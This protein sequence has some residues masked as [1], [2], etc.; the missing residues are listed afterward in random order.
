L[1]DEMEKAGL[2]DTTGTTAQPRAVFYG[3]LWLIPINRSQLPYESM[4][5]NTNLFKYKGPSLFSSGD[6]TVIWQDVKFFHPVMLLS[7]PKDYS[8]FRSSTECLAAVSMPDNDDTVGITDNKLGLSPSHVFQKHCLTV[9]N[10][11]FAQ[12]SAGNGNDTLLSFPVSPSAILTDSPASLLQQC[13]A[14]IQYL[15]QRE[16]SM[17]YFGQALLDTD[18]LVWNEGNRTSTHSC[19]AFNAALQCN[20]MRQLHCHSDQDRVV[21]PFLFYEMGLRSEYKSRRR[22]IDSYFQRR[23]HHRFFLW[24]EQEGGGGNDSD[25]HRKEGVEQKDAVKIVRGLCHWTHKGFG[26]GCPAFFKVVTGTI[27]SLGEVE[28]EKKKRPRITIGEKKVIHTN[29]SVVVAR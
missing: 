22:P 17:D 16:Q 25:H 13:N 15:Y 14:Y 26:K 1:E 29:R 24:T 7:Q 8:G 4:H 27:T 5:R 20:M 28:G 12:G 3:H 18:F 10:N 2:L 6:T 9:L 19:H 23:P 11:T 21:F